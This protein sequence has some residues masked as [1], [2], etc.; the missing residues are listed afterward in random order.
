MKWGEGKKKR[1]KK[2][3]ENEE[4]AEEESWRERE[5]TRRDGGEANRAV[6]VSGDAKYDFTAAASLVLWLTCHY[7]DF[8]HCHQTR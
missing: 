6:Q 3:I 7:S 1:G 4:G 8:L 2:G 5:K